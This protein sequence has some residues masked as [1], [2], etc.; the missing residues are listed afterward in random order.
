MRRTRAQD[1]STTLATPIDTATGG[2]YTAGPP[3]T[4]FSVDDANIIQEELVALATVKGASLDTA[5]TTTNQCAKAVESPA[6][7]ITGSS[8]GTDANIS[9]VWTNGIFA[10][11]S[12]MAGSD[13]TTVCAILASSFSKV[14][15]TGTAI[16][17]GRLNTGSGENCTVIGGLRNIVHGDNSAIVGGNDNLLTGTT[18]FIGGGAENKIN[19][20]ANRAA[21][22]GGYQNRIGPVSHATV[23]GGNTNFNSGTNSHIIGGRDNTINENGNYAGILGGLYNFITG[24]EAEASDYSEIIGG[25]YNEIKAAG[26]SVIGGGVLNQMSGNSSAIMGARRSKVGNTT[27]SAILGGYFNTASADYAVVIGGTYNSVSDSFGANSVIAGGVGNK[28]GGGNND[29]C[30]I[31]GG[32]FNTCSTYYAAV[33]GG[34]NNI[35]EGQAAIVMGSSVCTASNGASVLSSFSCSAIRTYAV[36]IGSQYSHIP[37]TASVDSVVMLASRR[38]N[39]DLAGTEEAYMTVGGYSAGTADVAPSWKI[40]SNGGTLHATNTAVQALDYAELFPNLDLFKHL[41]GRLL[42]R[43]G[44]GAKLA[45]TGDSIL[46]VVSVCPNIIGG[47]DTLGWAEQWVKDEWGATI[48]EE[49]DEISE[50]NGITYSRKVKVRKKNPKYDS[51]MKHTPRTK[52]PDEWTVV[53]LLGQIRVAID[54]TV[55]E[56]DYVV[57]GP[58]GIGTK[59]DIPGK[60]RPVECMEIEVP[61]DPILGYGIALCLVG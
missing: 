19:A 28:V 55:R 41:P 44:K 8:D 2:Y 47:S 57:S 58:D 34:N 43:K 14:Y 10:A 3:A 27:G 48:W 31:G 60:G 30:F 6:N 45:K 4:V 36:I 52:R 59:S 25:Q 46:G 12:S 9:S 5:G 21:I 1:N 39:S 37:A 7:L 26:N 50:R 61:F 11:T 17:G 13:S 38:C 53:G 23:L 15:N 18:S 42:T 29:A 22:I 33:I 40:E 32:Q 51:S 24:T 56:D 20:T 35:A 49:V 54:E 16:V